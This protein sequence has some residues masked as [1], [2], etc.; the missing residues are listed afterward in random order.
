MDFV[1]KLKEF[2]NVALEKGKE[3]GTAAKN[4]VEILS[5]E[6]EIE[7]CKTKIGDIIVTEKIKVDNDEISDCVAKIK[8]L[9]KDLNAKKE[10]LNSSK[11]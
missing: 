7:K 11:E 10:E 3:L 5:L 6:S 1:D 4:H 2:G 9:T 8:S